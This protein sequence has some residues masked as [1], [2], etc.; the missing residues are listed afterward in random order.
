M[1]LGIGRGDEVITSPFTFIATGEMIALAGREAGLRR[2]R[3]AHL[4]HRSGLLEARDH[5]AHQGDHAGVA[6]RAVR[7]HGRASMRSRASTACRSSKTRA[8]SLRRD[9]S[10]ASA[11]AR[12]SRVGSTSF[13]PSKPLGCYGDGGALFTNDDALAKVMRE[14]RVHGQDRRYHHPRL[15]HQRPARY[16]AGGGAA[17]EAG[18]LRRRSRGARA[19]RR[20]LRRADRARR[21]QR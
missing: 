14:I 9:V 7:R 5:A 4:Q 21:L 13:F 18:N 8:Q 15:G 2:H 3:R 17:R 19:H 20:A 6:V 10:A 12:L 1:A 11:P 16:A